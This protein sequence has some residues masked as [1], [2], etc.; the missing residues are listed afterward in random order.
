MTQPYVEYDFSEE[1]YAERDTHTNETPKIDE[2][3]PNDHNI[4][5][6]VD[7]E[8]SSRNIC[9]TCGDTDVVWYCGCDVCETLDPA[10]RP[11]W[12]T[13]DCIKN[14]PDHIYVEGF[15]K[16][17]FRKPFKLSKRSSSTNKE[18]S[19]EKKAKKLVSALKKKTKVLDGKNKK[20]ISIEKVKRKL[21]RLNET[22]KDL[23]IL[24]PNYYRIEQYTDIAA[25]DKKFETTVIFRKKY[26][27]FVFAPFNDAEYGLGF[28]M[29]LHQLK[30]KND[31]TSDKNAFSGSI[32]REIKPA[33]DFKN[34][35]RGA[36]G[37]IIALRVPNFSA[38]RFVI[39]WTYYQKP[40]DTVHFVTYV[41]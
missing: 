2:M 39:D 27:V 14:S 28:E 26:F 31:V 22:I 38:R 15:P 17:K 1:K 20:N 37:G 10:G 18:S 13:V 3:V 40:S 19:K 8:L 33:A 29:T 16:I 25:G 23:V 7:V 36:P 30:Q 11:N 41:V 6:L 35:T 5:D 24:E 12:C 21:T 32:R 34:I 4:L 9:H